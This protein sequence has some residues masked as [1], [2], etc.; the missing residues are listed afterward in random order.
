MRQGRGDWAQRWNA[1][2][3]DSRV[4]ELLRR[5]PED[6]A[7]AAVLLNGVLR[8]AAPYSVLSLAESY[9]RRH[10]SLEPLLGAG[11]DRLVEDS[12]RYPSGVAALLTLDRPARL[13]EAG[14]RRLVASEEPFV[15]PYLLLRLDDPV[16]SLRD[17]AVDAV[18][19]RLRV[20][21][22]D[23]LVP[24]APLLDR[25]AGRRRAGPLVRALRP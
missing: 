10:H 22:V 25:L 7:G 1:D 2:R 19:H 11:T 24:M 20:D 3:L 15:L 5:W 9:R 14:L 13:R 17:M 8:A 16:D 4:T 18:R 6:P 12:D 23:V 21:G